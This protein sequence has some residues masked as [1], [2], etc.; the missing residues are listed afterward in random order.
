M[1][2][3]EKDLNWKVWSNKSGGGSSSGSNGSSSGSGPIGAYN[4]SQ[5]QSSQNSNASTSTQQC[6]EPV[7][8]QQT[9]TTIRARIKSATLIQDDS[10]DFNKPCKFKIEIDSKEGYSAPVQVS[11]WGKYEENEYDLKCQ[12]TANPSN[13]I[14]EGDVT[15]YYIDQYYDDVVGNG[16][17]DASADYFL[18][19]AM[20]GANDF[21]GAPMTLPKTA[22]TKITIKFVT[23]ADGNAGIANAKVTIKLGDISKEATTDSDG[24]L[25]FDND[26]NA[27]EG[28]ITLELSSGDKVELP[29]QITA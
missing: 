11:L 29:I 10:T 20:K 13:M 6:E 4:P 9:Q 2:L 26:S 21:T 1:A 8:V 24:V 5:Q 19:V 23:D 16:K 28:T 14:A 12:S 7:T 17:S 22:G 25:C 27:S 18:K 15:L 3:S